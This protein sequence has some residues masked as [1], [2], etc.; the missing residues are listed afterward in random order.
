MNYL[1]K[2]FCSFSHF[3]RVQDRPIP[4]SRAKPGD[5]N[6]P[7]ADRMSPLNDRKSSYGERK[8]PL[9]DTSPT[10]ETGGSL[11]RATP[12]YDLFG[13]T[14]SSAAQE[15]EDYLQS[16][17]KGHKRYAQRDAQFRSPDGRKIPGDTRLSKSPVVEKGQRLTK[18]AAPTAKDFGRK[19]PT[20]K[21]T[22]VDAKGDFG[23]KTLGSKEPQSPERKSPLTKGASLLDFLTEGTQKTKEKPKVTIKGKQLDDELDDMFGSNK[24]Y[25][26]NKSPA[27]LSKSANQQ[28]KSP[29]DGHRPT[30]RGKGSFEEKEH[31]S[32]SPDY[33][34]KRNS[35]F[36]RENSDLARRQEE[37]RGI[38]EASDGKP[39]TLPKNRKEDASSVCEEIPLDPNLQMQKAE[40]KAMK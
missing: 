33:M 29:I 38:Y 12:T 7:Y 25:L 19:T 6:S 2:Q 22:P 10:R 30:L 32:I 35:M 14:R 40:E 18:S 8:S 34:S 15:V 26:A 36:D 21:K 3:R 20:G 9:I 27:N 16:D 37:S 17:K 31:G 1:L 28:H 39:K 23:R 11:K 5:R 4:Q 13:K 24:R